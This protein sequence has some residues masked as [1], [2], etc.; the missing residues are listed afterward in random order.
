[1]IVSTKIVCILL[2]IYLWL[3]ILSRYC[4]P[5]MQTGKVCP[6]LAR[7]HGRAS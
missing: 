4:N 2:N 6:H 5:K 1:M 3:Q 7:A